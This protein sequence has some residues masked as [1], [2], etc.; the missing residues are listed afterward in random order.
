MIALPQD[1]PTCTQG[2]FSLLLGYQ[3][4]SLNYMIAKALA[5]ADC[6]RYMDPTTMT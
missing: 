4:A 2:Y 1:M 3:T 6:R 5:R